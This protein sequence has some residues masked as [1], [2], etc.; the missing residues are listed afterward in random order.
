MNVFSGAGPVLKRIAFGFPGATC[1]NSA[2]L[3]VAVA[4]LIGLCLPK[5]FVRSA[6]NGSART[7][8]ALASVRLSRR[9]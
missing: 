3:N 1:S 8:S 2:V 6:R 9:R 4:T 5:T 7:S